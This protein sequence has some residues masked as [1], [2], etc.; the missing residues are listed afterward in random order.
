VKILL[1]KRLRA[2]AG[3]PVGVLLRTAKEME[4]VLARNPFPDAPPNRTVAI[5]LDEPPPRDTLLN[6][7]GAKDEEVG[8]GKRE[9]YVHYPNGMGKSKL[10]IAAAGM[11]T[12]RN[13][14][15]V[16]KLAM[17]AKETEDR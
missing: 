17:M 6:V 10:R 9:I 2:H 15:T 12:A 8:L 4:Q 11:G 5:F 14:N 13:M 3:K 16:A 1:E 7:T